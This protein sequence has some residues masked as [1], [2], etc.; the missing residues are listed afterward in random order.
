[1]NEVQGNMDLMDMKKEKEEKDRAEEERKKD[2]DTV[3]GNEL[4]DGRED[5]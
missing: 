2:G 5:L 3:S 1:M 4:E